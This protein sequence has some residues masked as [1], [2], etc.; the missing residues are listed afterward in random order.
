[1]LERPMDT[2]FWTSTQRSRDEVRNVAKPSTANAAR[3]RR[4]AAG[5]D[6]VPTENCRCWQPLP[7]RWRFLGRPKS[8]ARNP[9]NGEPEG[10]RSERPRGARADPRS[11]GQW[12]V[13]GGQ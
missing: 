13:V 11:S 7:T 2:D 9:Q 6:P 1:A 12:S 10:E 4:L 3:G 5:R 8:T